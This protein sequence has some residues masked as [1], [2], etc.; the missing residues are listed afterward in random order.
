MYD[1]NLQPITSESKIPFKKVLL[2]SNGD[3]VETGFLRSVDADGFVFSFTSTS[4]G[5][6]GEQRPLM[7]TTIHPTH[8]AILNITIE[9]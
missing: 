1:V 4:V 5:I 9:K 3:T 7:R 6:N 8:Y 2:L